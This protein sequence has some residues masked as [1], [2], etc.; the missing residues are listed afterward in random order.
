MSKHRAKVN[1]AKK[2]N[3]DRISRENGKVNLS[4]KQIEVLIE[5]GLLKPNHN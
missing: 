3:S 1:K 2:F 5:M 4:K